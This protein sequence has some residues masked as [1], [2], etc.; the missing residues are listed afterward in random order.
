MQHLEGSGTPVLYVGRTVLRCLN[1]KWCSSFAG[2]RLSFILRALRFCIFLI[3]DLP[4]HQKM[5]FFIS[6]GNSI[7]Y[8]ML[9]PGS[10]GISALYKQTSDSLHSVWK[11]V[12]VFPWN[13]SCLKPWNSKQWTF[14]TTI[15][16]IVCHDIVIIVLHQ[17]PGWQFLLPIDSFCVLVRVYHTDWF[18]CL[19]S[20]PIPC[21][22]FL[23]VVSWCP[24]LTLCQN[25]G[26]ASST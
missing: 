16:N 21:L 1:L 5:F 13:I 11:T 23:W 26:W 25:T 4:F 24:P 12:R 18:L 10:S 7:K 19:L 2:G 3:L 8:G 20:C 22:C 15:R 9:V 6:S 14:S 17:V